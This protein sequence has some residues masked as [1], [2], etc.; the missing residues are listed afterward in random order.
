MNLTLRHLHTVSNQDGTA[1]LDSQRGQIATFNKTGCIV[2]EM[3]QRGEPVEAIIAE[4]VQLTG[5]S[6]K[7]ERASG[8]VFA[9]AR[10][11]CL[12]VSRVYERREPNTQG[13]HFS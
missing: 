12:E 4:L 11:K 7:E 1:V 2:W 3:T 9:I 6:E 5:A 10:A 13:R 8:K